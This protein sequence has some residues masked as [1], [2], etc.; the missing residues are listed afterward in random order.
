V[1]VPVRHNHL[2]DNL[3]DILVGHLHRSVHLGP[4]GY[5]IVVLDLKF[6]AHFPHHFVI[7]V[8]VVVCD[9]LPRKTILADN[10]LF[11]EPD[12]HTLRD[13]SV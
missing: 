2:L 5:G 6:L 7:Q 3:L 8:G 11:D 10:L 9:N 13:A 12:H 1:P 4:I